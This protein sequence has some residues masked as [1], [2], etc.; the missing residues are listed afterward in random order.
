MQDTFKTFAKRLKDYYGD[1]L[2][3]PEVYPEV[4]SYQVKIY[5]YIY[6]K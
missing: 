5:M 1:K 3:D 2:V 6:G 4:F